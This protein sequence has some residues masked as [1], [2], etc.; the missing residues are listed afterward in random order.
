M[1]VLFDKIWSEMD[2][3]TKETSEQETERSEVVW[4]LMVS[5]GRASWAEGRGNTQSLKHAL[6]A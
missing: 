5:G 4:D 2:S 1:G 6:M 3:L